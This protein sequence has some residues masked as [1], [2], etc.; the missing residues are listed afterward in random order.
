MKSKPE[1]PLKPQNKHTKELL[2]KTGTNYYTYQ[3]IKQTPDM[4][5]FLDLDT[6]KH[7][8]FMIMVKG[9]PVGNPIEGLNNVKTIIDFLENLNTE[10]FLQDSQIKY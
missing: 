10:F 1:K 6:K 2:P 3:L 9:V 8:Y 4:L 5:P 7:K